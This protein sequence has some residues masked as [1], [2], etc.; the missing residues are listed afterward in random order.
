MEILNNQDLKKLNSE[1]NNPTKPFKYVVIDN[2]LM[3]TL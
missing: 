2:F 3:K 1:F